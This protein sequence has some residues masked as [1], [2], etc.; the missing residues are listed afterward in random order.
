M[1]SFTIENAF[2][3]IKDGSFEEALPILEGVISEEPEDWNAIYLAGV[4][5]RAISDLDRSAAFLKKAVSIKGD[6]ASVWAALGITMQLMENFSEAISAFKKAVKL[7]PEYFEGYNSLGLTY[8]KMGN[9]DEALKHYDNASSVLSREASREAKRNGYVTLSETDEGKKVY[10]VEAGNIPFVKNYLKNDI[11]W[12]TVMN[13]IG[14][15]YLEM[16][17]YDSAKDAFIESIEFTPEGMSYKSPHG[18]LDILSTK[19]A[20]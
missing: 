1:P 12:A 6:E 5:C 14:G 13:N 15:V 9:L 18:G 10:T 11:R 19:F 4:C 8:K 2:S 17:D 7:D 16:G 3:L 20:K